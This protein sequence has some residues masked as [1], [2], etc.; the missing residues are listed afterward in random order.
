MQISFDPYDAS[1]RARLAAILRLIGPE[2]EPEPDC[3]FGPYIARYA[4]GESP[5][6][7]RR[8]RGES[9]AWALDAAFYWHGV[10]D[11]QASQATK[12]Q[13]L[14]THAKLHAG[15]IPLRFTHSSEPK[16][17]APSA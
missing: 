3:E 7:M 1:D 10:L 8:E 9:T 2:V 12:R 16:R 15:V 5:L 4:A 13:Y 14:R 6:L 11:S 17:Q